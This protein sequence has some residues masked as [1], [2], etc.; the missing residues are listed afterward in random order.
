[1]KSSPYNNFDYGIKSFLG[2]ILFMG[3]SFSFFIANHNFVTLLIPL[4]LIWS[5]FYLRSSNKKY[6][7]WYNNCAPIRACFMITIMLGVLLSAMSYWFSIDSAPLL[8]TLTGIWIMISALLSGI[9]C[10]GKMQK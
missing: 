10:N 2:N 9:Y 3:M 6:S 5:N 8:I 4:T 7:Y 1:M